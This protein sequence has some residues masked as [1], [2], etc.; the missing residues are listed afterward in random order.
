MDCM[1]SGPSYPETKK[2]VISVLSLA[3][4]IFFLCTFKI[5]TFFNTAKCCGQPYKQMNSA[6]PAQL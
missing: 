1:K 2:C 4:F 5:Y 3:A 6:T